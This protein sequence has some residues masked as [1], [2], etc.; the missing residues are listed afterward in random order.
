VGLMTVTRASG[1][2]PPTNTQCR[3]FYTIVESFS[4]AE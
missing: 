1:I 2:H 4:T 3:I